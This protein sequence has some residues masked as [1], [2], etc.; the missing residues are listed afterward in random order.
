MKKVF[1][2]S[3][4]KTLYC[5]VLLA[6]FPATITIV[7]SGLESRESYLHEVDSRA[8]DL[9][10]SAA[11]HHQ[12]LTENT[13]M[14]LMTLAQLEEIRQQDI[15]FSISLLHNLLEQYPVYNNLFITDK[16]GRVFATG[17]DWQP[18]LQVQDRRYFQE[19]VL[20]RDFS[21]G[22]NTLDRI[23]GDKAMHFAYPVKDKRGK[24]TAVIVGSMRSGHYNLD[25]SILDSI[26]GATFK[27]IDRYGHIVYSY[28]EDK[29]RPAD[30]MA[31]SKELWDE[32]LK[33]ESNTGTLFQTEGGRTTR[34]TYQRLNLPGQ[35]LPYLVV[36][37]FV[38]ESSATAAANQVLWRDLGYLAAVTV[39]AL[40]ITWFLGQRALVMP[41]STLLSAARNLARG[42]LGARSGLGSLHG[43]VGMLAR[44]FDEM[45]EALET[46]TEELVNAKVA[47][48]VANK[49]K[50]EFLA[51]MS[52]EIRTPMNAV[53]GMAYLALKTNLSPKQHNYISK[54]YAAGNTLLGIINDI[55]D[56]SKIESGQL[57]ME[58]VPFRLDDIFENIAVLVGQKADE[59]G[60]EILYSIDSNV[61]H[62][63]VGDPL[64]LG[65]ILTNLSNNSVKFTEKGEIVISCKL[66][67]VWEGKARLRF[68]VKD[69]GI[70][71]T[72]EQQS[73]L[74]QAFTQADGS[75]TRRFGGTGLGLTITKRLVEMMDGDIFV[76]SEHGAGSTITFSASFGIGTEDKS[77]DHPTSSALK[78]RILVIDDN[79]AAREVLRSLI[80]G[81]GFRVS[82]A[83]SA[84]EAFEMLE[85][86]DK[87]EPFDLVFI[88]WRMPE[89]DGVEAIRHI[90]NNLNL[91]NM[92]RIIM[93]TAFGRAEI[94]QQAEQ[95]GAM[96]FLHKPINQSM[97]LD[98]IMEALSGSRS[99]G[100]SHDLPQRTHS[101]YAG[102]M[103][104]DDVVRDAQI[105]LVEDNMVNQ[106]IAT[107]LLE[108]AGAQVTVANNGQE[109]VDFVFNSKRTPPFDLVLMDLQ[110]PIM[111]GYGAT[112]KIRSEPRFSSMPIIAMTAHALIEERQRC[113]NVGMNDHI[114][115]PIEVDKFFAVLTHWLKDVVFGIQYSK[116]RSPE[117]GLY[118]EDREVDT[119]THATAGTAEAV[120]DKPDAT[121]SDAAKPVSLES[122]QTI[123]PKTQPAMQSDPRPNPSEVRQPSA[124]PGAPPGA[125][126]G[127]KPAGQA[128]VAAAKPT[129]PPLPGI[130]T[131]KAL[132]RLGGNV[133]LYRNLLS[134]FL[135][136]NGNADMELSKI[137]EEGDI[138]AAER[139][140]HTLKGLA[141][142][143]GADDLT[144][145]AAELELAFRNG[146]DGKD[147]AVQDMLARCALELK[148]VR[149][150]L[151]PLFAEQKAAEQTAAPA[152]PKLDKEA[153]SR[154]L[155]ELRGLLAE[156]DSDA[157]RVVEENRAM[158][159]ALFEARDLNLL[160]EAV[161][162]FDFENALSLLDKAKLS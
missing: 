117:S 98:T 25:F 38:P 162:R 2:G 78:S 8:G 50:S 1:S 69:T 36:A 71:M 64:R 59:K 18:N 134:Q 120:P 126:S 7:Y 156:D 4:S 132:S 45:A 129:M 107:E 20:T 72:Q 131:V 74:F 160:V 96:A 144:S 62:N 135:R 9:V 31:M 65:Q 103:I 35:R 21:V 56:F 113:L 24:V 155:Q 151:E 122:A 118:K 102:E 75:T 81:F 30:T 106:Q 84:K 159:Q 121:K 95:A 153:A 85:E 139:L 88:D 147:D 12:L 19:A 37:V 14:L 55:L 86:A 145:V 27:A 152:I 33:N 104:R 136:Y 42:N 46:R 39:F 112:K 114:S 61:P 83:A 91:S 100:M 130:D 119:N 48:D 124:S 22:D 161:Q 154:L 146:T 143:I 125:P 138:G 52:H 149:E 68:S 137:L 23:T 150:V 105:L 77:T 158:L 140:S 40:F 133:K 67:E 13:R 101:T 15:S 108:D 60:L 54:I 127:V 93:V 26:K 11:S 51:N 111:D 89:M 141:A 6:V 66:E 58:H 73:K 97:L 16:D 47:A 17:R 63:L 80:V 79:D 10:H 99:S 148:A 115:K 43:E 53:I 92:P 142:S 3:I 34:I 28:P 49:A 57:D 109:A 32:I 44:S 110:M 70:G 116:P 5:I 41:L 82:S 76:E 90:K 94:Q 87:S 29:D 157:M 128:G 123:P